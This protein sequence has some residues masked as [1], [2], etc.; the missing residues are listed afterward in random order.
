MTEVRLPP[1]KRFDRDALDL[2]EDV[3]LPVLHH[4]GA[5]VG[6]DCLEVHLHALYALMTL[7]LSGILPNRIHSFQLSFSC[8]AEWINPSIVCI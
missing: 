6:V 1:S 3:L 8:T 7:P 2:N 5:R 4:L